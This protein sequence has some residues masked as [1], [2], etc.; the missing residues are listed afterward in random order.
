MSNITILIALP[1]GILGFLFLFWRRLKEDYP[2]DQ[3]FT[4]GFIVAACILV[5]FFSGLSVYNIQHTIYFSPHGLWFWLA[6][7]FGGVGFFVSFMKLKLRFFETLE[8]AGL[9][10]L[11]WIF[12]IY[13][14]NLQIFSILR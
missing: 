3:I 2:G 13:I 9:G 10:F 14:V 8:A 7:L 4:F 5:G 11:F 12:T 1:I 6:F